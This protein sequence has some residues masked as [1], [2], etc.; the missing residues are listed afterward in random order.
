MYLCVC[1][2]THI[3]KNTHIYMYIFGWACTYVY[4]YTYINTHTYTASGRHGP[5]NRRKIPLRICNIYHDGGMY[6]CMYVYMHVCM[7]LECA[8]STYYALNEYNTTVTE[9]PQVS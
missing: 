1:M 8:I 2:Y 5:A 7:T 3:Q 6:V 4:I 9:L